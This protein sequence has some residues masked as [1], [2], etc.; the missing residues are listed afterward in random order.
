MQPRVERHVAQLTDLINRLRK[1]IQ[2]KL[3][4]EIDVGD[5]ESISRIVEEIGNQDVTL[6]GIAE[7]V[8]EQSGG[9]PI[10]RQ[11]LVDITELLDTL[12]QLKWKYTEGTTGRGRSSAGILNSTGCS[13]VWGSMYPFNPYPFPWANHLFQDAAS[14]AMGVFEGHMSKMADGFKAIRMAEAELSGRRLDE[15]SMTYF[16]WQ[17]FTDEE[18]ELC[19]PVVALG[20]DGAMYDIGFQNLSRAMISGKPVKVLVLD[21]QAY[22][23][24]G[25]QACTSGFFG[26]ISDMAQ[27]GKSAQGKQEIRKEMGLIGMAHRTT[28]VMQSSIANPNHMIEGFIEGLKARRPAL[29]NLYTPCQPEHGIGDDM[30]AHQARLAVESRAYPLFRYDPD[31][32]NTPEQ[33]ITLE[34]NPAIDEDWP[35]YT[36]AYVDSGRHK[37]MDVPMTFADFA[38]TE[39]RFR[40]HFRVAPS[41][42]WNDNMIPLSEFLQLDEDEREGRFPYVWSV[43]REQQLLRLLVSEP[44]VR[45]CED[46]RD[47]WSML[48]AI[49]RADDKQIDRG[50]VEAEV[51]RELA[52]KLASGLMEFISGDSGAAVQRQGQAS[53]GNG[54][55]AADGTYMAPWIDTDK[56]TSCD[57]CVNLNPSIFAYNEEKK[58]VIKNPAGGPYRDLVKAA[59]RCTAGVIH[60][61][62]PKDRSAKGIEKLIAR[63]EKFNR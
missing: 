63:A 30:S 26:Q 56:C 9:E 6:A 20:G 53:D 50:E 22:S 52:D 62:L 25:G 8:E 37:T 13:S 32:G 46:R 39:I 61:G 19:P 48:R 58:A 40:K 5:P 14:M 12:Q 10:D 27:F 54:S 28:Y 36:L 51:R 3:V 38:A 41:E 15:A 55:P 59:E 29:F 33:C 16:N 31:L 1:H 2:Q 49:A 18:W 45:S 60:P 24:T 42:T 17:D 34:G 35:S 4:H 11:W 57:E 21:T 7:R 47:F 23:N 43:D 44:M